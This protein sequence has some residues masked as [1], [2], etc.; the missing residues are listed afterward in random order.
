MLARILFEMLPNHHYVSFYHVNTSLIF[1]SFATVSPSI[2]GVCIFDST[3][4]IDVTI[5]PIIVINKMYHFH[6]YFYFDYMIIIVQNTYK[7]P[8]KLHFL[9]SFVTLQLILYLFEYRN[10]NCLPM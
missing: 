3:V 1:I 9:M 2:S 6:L 8:S 5:P 10:D 4:T 7:I